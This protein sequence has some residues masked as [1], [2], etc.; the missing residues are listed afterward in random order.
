VLSDAFRSFVCCLSTGKTWSI[1]N[2]LTNCYARIRLERAADF[3]TTFGGMGRETSKDIPADRSQRPFDIAARK[4]PIQL[5]QAATDVRAFFQ[6]INFTV[7]AGFGCAKTRSNS[8]KPSSPC[9]AEAETGPFPLKK[10]LKMPAW[11][12]MSQ[13]RPSNAQTA[14]SE[15]I[16][17]DP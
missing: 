1:I 14:R 8:R 12:F 15:G 4:S 2:E 16:L 6:L 3:E 11:E 10:G 5:W 17:P 13:V 9:P 7:S